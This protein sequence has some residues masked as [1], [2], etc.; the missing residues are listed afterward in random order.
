MS[1]IDFWAKKFESKINLDGENLYDSKPF[2]EKFWVT[3]KISGC[4]KILCQR[5][6]FDPKKFELWGV[7]P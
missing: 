5:K 4:R 3:E 2:F 1:K 7:E 6:T